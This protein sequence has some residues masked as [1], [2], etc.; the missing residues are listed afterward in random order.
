LENHSLHRFTGNLA[1]PSTVKLLL[2]LGIDPAAVDDSGTSALFIALKGD[3]D[4]KCQ[5]AIEI[6]N[7]VKAAANKKEI[8]AAKKELRRQNWHEFTLAAPDK[9]SQSAYLLIPSLAY[10]GFSI[11]ARE[12][13]YRD[14]PENNWMVPV[15]TFIT[16]FVA[17]AA[18]SFLPF[19][20][21]GASLSG[22]D[23]LLPVLLGYV[24]VPTAG[25]ITGCIMAANQQVKSAF[26][27]KPVLY[28][29]SPVLAGAI[30]IPLFIYIWQN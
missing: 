7:M 15:N 11:A 9:L 18:V 20:L 4:K 28:Y 13:I 8:A 12:G 22:W 6:R 5:E 14:N 23:R 24:V 10:L 1:H 17:G 29:S 25:I 27:E 16:G 3:G 21:W 2:D 26:M 19:L 30:C